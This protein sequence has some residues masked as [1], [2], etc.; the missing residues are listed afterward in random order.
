ML[1]GACLFVS[2]VGIAVEILNGAILFSDSKAVNKLDI[3]SGKLKR[4]W[5]RVPSAFSM[6]HQEGVSRIDAQNLLVH[7]ENYSDSGIYVIDT[8]GSGASYLRNGARPFFVRGHGKFLF[9]YF[10]KSISSAGMRLFMSNTDNPKGSSILVDDNAGSGYLL[11]DHVYQISPD[12]VLIEGWK[13]G[14][15]RYLKYN[16]V[17]KGKAYSV[18]SKPCSSFAWRSKTGQMLCYDYVADEYYLTGIDW[19]MSE[20]LP[21]LDNFM[22]IGYS[23]EIDSLILAKE[24]FLENGHRSS[25]DVLLYEFDSGKITSVGRVPNIASQAFLLLNE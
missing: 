23:E 10:D 16:V 7:I 4:L 24:I 15:K 19:S 21:K 12:E 2:N 8:A 6:I 17:S 11:S 25:F 22:V 5:P 9:L 14:R 20:S 13:D 1:G 18:P 3:K